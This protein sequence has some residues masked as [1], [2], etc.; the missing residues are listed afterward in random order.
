MTRRPLIAVLVPILL[1]LLAGVALAAEFSR[2]FTFK[3]D[4]LKV[5]NLVGSV[6]VVSAPGDEFEVQV[7]VR[8]KDAS[9]DF[10]EFLTSR[11]GG[12]VLTIKFPVKEHDRYVYPALGSHSKTTIHFNDESDN[13]GSWLKH[14]FSGLSGTKVTVQG[15]GRGQEVWADVV[16]AVPRDA[17][18]EV[19]QGVGGIRAA[20]LEA[21][22]DLDIN[23]GGI[24]VRELKGDLLAD[25]GSGQ[26]VASGVVGEVNIDTGSGGVEVSDCRGS[27]IRVDTGSGRVVATDLSCEYLLIDTGS[28]AVKAR[29]VVADAAKVDTGSGSVTLELDRMGEGKFVVD[30]GSGSIDLALPLDASARVSADTGSGRVANEFPGADVVRKT[31]SEMELLVGSGAARVSL[32]AGSGGI[33]VRQK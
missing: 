32:D 11:D 5:A 9:E 14:L 16:I 31:R 1:S 3:D 13:G 12:D 26:V 30:T 15:Q 23:S 29:R 20:D 8:G 21:E 28:G 4:R 22:L 10:L 24:E 17:R 7:F 19:K 2:D 25:T 33:T 18:L 6:E 27:D